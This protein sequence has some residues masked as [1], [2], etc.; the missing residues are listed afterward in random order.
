MSDK[1]QAGKGS[2]PRPIS[3]PLD[4]FGKRWDKI[5]KKKVKDGKTNRKN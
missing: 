4:E 2:K 1:R 3:V 5:F